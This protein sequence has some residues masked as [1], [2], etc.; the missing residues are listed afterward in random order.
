MASPEKGNPAIK[1]FWTR[2]IQKIRFYIGRGKERALVLL[3]PLKLM[4]A[5]YIR[6]PRVLQV[7]SIY[8]LALLLAGG[9]YLWRSAGLRT[10]NPYADKIKF[11][12]LEDD[13]LPGL[14]DHNPDLKAP[15]QAAVA[16]PAVAGPETE[17]SGTL[18]QPL[19]PVQG[20]LLRKFDDNYL[21]SLAPLDY[22][23]RRKCKWIEIETAPGAEIGSI[24]T[25]TVEKIISTGYPGQALKIKHDNGLVAYYASLGEIRV[26]EGQ[27]VE[28]GEI[29]ATVRQEEA[30]PQAY[31]YLE[32]WQEGRRVDPLSALP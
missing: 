25:G 1:I 29:I 22:V 24:F 23:R 2:L 17:P 9:L 30:S 31:L 3:L 5:A 20:K 10:I 18:P 15:D 26:A 11:V 12:E 4:K 6:C 32:I 13:A 27:R 7:G 16:E 14:K 28:C 21:E 19:W 8:L